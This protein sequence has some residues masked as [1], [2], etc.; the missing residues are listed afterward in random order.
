MVNPQ[1]IV[2]EEVKKSLAEIGTTVRASLWW[3][4]LQIALRVL[5]GLTLWTAWALHG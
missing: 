3:V 2:D 4:S 1:K 5:F